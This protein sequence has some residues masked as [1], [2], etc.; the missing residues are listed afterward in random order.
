M[1]FRLSE[2]LNAKI[3]GG[4]LKVHPLDENPYADWSGH[5][6]T[7]ERTRYILLSNTK[8]LYSIVM[9]GKGI[10]H[11]G[12]FIDRAL[13]T[14]REFMQDDGQQFAYHRFIAPA[15]AT[16]TSAKAFNRSVTGSMNELIA[17]A[18][19]WLAEGELSP[20]DVA[21]RLNDI[22][23]SSLPGPDGRGYGRPREAFKA[24]LGSTPAA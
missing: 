5:L 19:L 4:A 21:F 6:F 11:D 14:I 2:K 10:T 17:H 7:V 8:S 13:S 12:Q 1:I 22:L 20:H 16:V 9:Y 3:K 18:T 24:L 23:I 15:S